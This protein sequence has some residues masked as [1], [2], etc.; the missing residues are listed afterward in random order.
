MRREADNRAE[1]FADSSWRRV[2]DCALHLY[3]RGFQERFAPDMSRTFAVRLADV[4][5]DRGR[6]GAAWFLL[7]E[8]VGLMGSVSR[9]RLGGSD[10]ET[11]LPPIPGHRPQPLSILRQ[12]MRHGARRLVRSPGFTIASI[13]TLGLGVGATTAIYSLVHSTVLSP[14]PYPESERLVWLDHTAPGL[15]NDGGGLGMTDGLYA[16]YR[17][18]LSSLEDMAIWTYRPVTL[19]A[20]D[21]DRVSSVAVTPS[22][23]D[24]LRVRPMIGRAFTESEVSTGGAG[25]LI[26]H[27]LWQRWF[28]GEQD[29]VGR[30]I[31]ANGNPI[32]IIG[33]MPPSFEFPDREIE[34][35][36]PLDID[37]TRFGGFS[38]EGVARLAPGA[39]RESVEAEARVAIPALGDIYGV[40]GMLDDTRLAP[41]FPSLKASIVDEAQRTLW[42]LLGS[43]AFVLLLACANV[44]NL[45]LVRAESRHQEA[46][47]RRALGAG[48][49]D[50]ARYFLAEGF[51]LSLGGGVV[52][53]GLATLAVKILVR[54][55]PEHLPRLSELSV[56]MPALLMTGAI[57]LGTTLLFG[58]GP[59]LR[60]GPS[61]ATTVKTAGRGMHGGRASSRGRNVLVAAQVSLALVLLVATG[62]MG[63]TFIHLVSLDPGFRA[64]GTLTFRVGL[65]T[66]SYA[67]RAEGVAFH[68]EAIE[69]LAA[70]P[71]VEVAGATT[72]LPLCGNWIG[73]QLIVEGRPED[74]NHVPG[75]VAIRRVTEDY[76]AAVQTR[77]VAG[78][79]LTRFDEESGS[80][81]AVISR[82]LAADYWPGED[83]IGA[84]FS[85]DAGGDAWYTV[86]G[87]VENTPIRAL[88]DSP[89]PMAYLPLL[90]QNGRDA[91]P[92]ELAYVLRTSVRPQ[93][94]I[95]P[96]RAVIRSMDPEVPLARVITLED[97][98]SES[99]VSTAFTT[100]VLGIA[101]GIALLLGVVG[102]YGVISYMVGRRSK[103]IG[104]RSAL[105][106]RPGQVSRSVLAQGSRVTAIGLVIGT[107]AALGLT[108]IMQTML[109][110]VSP[111]D[112]LPFV[113]VPL[114]LL[115][116]AL[117]ATYIPARRASR[118]DPA[119][120]LRAD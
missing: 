47:V 115:L 108:R 36:A 88:S 50:I 2:Y 19:S 49:A 94:L 44:A 86:V 39:T 114:L 7:G 63:R 85:S 1:G 95:I 67:T 72:C 74:P 92:Y 23:F 33:V 82:E 91:S 104:I 60:R 30:T 26:S 11:E 120:T 89:P 103:E 112:P 20:D 22:F 106:A 28:G 64:E 65:A 117:A 52:G 46:A 116:V 75:V 77:L 18:R 81:A 41:L 93:S 21:P 79:L 96:A 62:L 56:S 101:A 80:G 53:V 27:G 109:V 51:L 13:L 55:G 29:A 61:L 40:R 73:T 12:E 68:R 102:I 6:A 70:L 105:G 8:F 24:A 9:V 38:R 15:G 78:R 69:R 84:R 99:N 32:E 3:P 10:P 37:E 66:A 110:G 118:V 31:R 57:L 5:A 34:L 42:I 59:A 87:I 97:V 17:E 100:V 90:Y 54:V 119:E 4:R 71:G 76:F 48:R 35:W 113:V 83:P 45:L 58:L 16:H 14:L 107:V 43:V 98:V 111:T 25:I